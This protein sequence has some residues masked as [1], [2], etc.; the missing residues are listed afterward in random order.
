MRFGI[1]Y[2]TIISGV[3]STA[4]YLDFVDK[5]CWKGRQV[6]PELRIEL[7]RVELSDCDISD[8]SKQDFSGRD[9]LGWQFEISR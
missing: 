1:V 7:L 5:D 9:V 4:I 6:G 3:L 8:S 2:T